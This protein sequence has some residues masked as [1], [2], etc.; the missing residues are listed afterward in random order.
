MFLKNK[1]FYPSKILFVT[2]ILVFNLFQFVLLASAEDIPPS[3][4]EIQG[5]NWKLYSHGVRNFAFMD[6]YQCALYRM[7]KEKILD[8]VLDLK[9]PI[10]IRIQILTSNLPDNVPSAWKE[11]IKPEVT[12][13]T[14]NRFKKQYLKIEEGD[15][16]I[17]TFLPSQSTNLYLNG[18]K[19]LVDPGPGL[20]QA[21]LDQWVGLNPI[22]EDLKVALIKK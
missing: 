9:S 1:L 2:G 14:Y 20:M 17:F 6:L 10:A 15:I 7:Q 16:L 21:L 11:A 12:D 19:E 13:K 18:K 22:S 3:N 5:S 4:I 8:S